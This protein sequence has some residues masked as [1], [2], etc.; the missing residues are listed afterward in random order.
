[1]SAADKLAMTDRLP[2]DR[3]DEI[4]LA[5]FQSLLAADPKRAIET[6]G[7]VLTPDSKASETL[8]REILR[9]WR[10]PR[11]FASNALVSNIDKNIGGKEFVSLLR[12]TLIKGFQNEKNLKIRIE[13]IYTLASLADAQS[14][15]Y[16]KRLYAT[17]NDR[18]IK[19]DIINSLGTSAG[20]PSKFSSD[21]IQRQE[22]G[23]NISREQ[24]RKIQIEILLQIVRDE[25][26][27]ELRRLAFANL[28]RFQSWATSEQAF[29]VMTR[30]YDSATD[31]EF[32]VTIVRAFAESKQSQATKKLIDIARNDKSDKL[33]LEAIYLLRD[34]KDPGVIKVLEELIK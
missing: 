11:L 18:D 19:K 27:T 2:L 7:E 1:M 17:E 4:K 25:K 34:N 13:I 8:K 15:D 9:V 32:K 14:L 23:F 21:T 20:D 33:R 26:D 16:L 24:K 3:A 29:D 10:N 12:E 31:E 30:I 28:R 6:M 22:T 5:A